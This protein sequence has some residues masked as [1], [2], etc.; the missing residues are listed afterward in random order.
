MPARKLTTRPDAVR[1]AGQ[2]VWG[3]A[4]VSTDEQADSGLSL[5]EQRHTIE[6]RCAENG[7]SLEGLYVDDSVSGATPLAHRREGRKL[8][9][10]VRSGDIVIAAKM[11][12]MF[13]SA[14]DALQTI[15]S[16]R[17]RKIS[18][19]LLDLCGDIS[20]NG[21]AEPIVTILTAV[22]HD[23]ERVIMRSRVA[24]AGT[25]HGVAQ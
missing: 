8:F 15:Q 24:S 18:L 23:A 21:I 9:A 25:K 4:R 10:A 12:R 2:R 3:Y 6:A 22:A 16:F 20:G 19:W 11:D 14:L 1:S 7:W 17:Q 5:E 13:R